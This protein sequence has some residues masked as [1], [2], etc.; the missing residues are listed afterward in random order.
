MKEKGPSVRR[1]L[2]SALGAAAALAVM[3]LLALGL[4]LLLGGRRPAGQT[5]ATSP[6]LHPQLTV[7]ALLANPPAAGEAVEVDAYFSGAVPTYLPGPPRVMDD[8]VY[9]PTYSPWMAALTDQPFTPLLRVLNGTSS[10]PLPAGG[11]WLAATTPEGT[12][13]GQDGRA[14]PALPC[15]LPRPPGRPGL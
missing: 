14:R 13:P 15:P 7:A 3:A 6:T 11:A 2:L 10:N 8:Q 5:P 12:Q 1:N 9:C 4:T